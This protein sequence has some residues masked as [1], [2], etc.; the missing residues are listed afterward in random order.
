MNASGGKLHEATEGAGYHAISPLAVGSLVLGLLSPLSL[1]APLLWIVPALAIGLACLAFR[2]IANSGGDQAGRSTAFAGL[3]LGIIFAAAGPVQSATTRYLLTEQVRPICDAW[4]D[5]LRN[6][7]PQKAHQLMQPALR[8]RVLNDEL[9]EYYKSNKEN[10]EELEQFVASPVVRA[11]LEYGPQ[12]EVRLFD[13]ASI[14]PASDADVIELTYAVTYPAESGKQTFF[15]LLS[16][17]RRIMQN[18][19]V[20]WRITRDRTGGIPQALAG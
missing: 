1:I 13:V 17:E 11:I 16:V 20:A 14:T 4:F 2:A 9:W 10:R 12:C 8:R 18:G 15:V 7:E 6:G 5:S 19:E 3:A